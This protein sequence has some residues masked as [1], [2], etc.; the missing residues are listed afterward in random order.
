[1]DY[2]KINCLVLDIKVLDLKN[3]IHI[4]FLLIKESRIGIPKPNYLFLG[5]L[6]NLIFNKKKL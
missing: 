4:V 6:E 2:F 1:M 5:L 3:G